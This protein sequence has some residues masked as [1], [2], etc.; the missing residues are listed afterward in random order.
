[1]RIFR[2]GP[3]DKAN[4]I[5]RCQFDFDHG[6]VRHALDRMA[7]LKVHLPNDASVLYAEGLI[8]TEGAGEGFAAFE[9]YKQAYTVDRDHPYAAPNAVLLAPSEA[10]FLETAEAA[11]RVAPHDQALRQI[12]DGVKEALADGRSPARIQMDLALSRME[13]GEFGEAA[14]H[15][16]IGLTDATLTPNEERDARRLRA[17]CL[18]KVDLMAERERESLGEAIPPNDRVALKAAKRELDKVI[19]I[20]EYD[21]EVWNLKAAWSSLLHDY[22]E[23]IESAEKALELRPHGYA[24]A[25]HNKA[26]ALFHLGRIDEAIASVEE[27]LRK[28]EASGDD[29]D[30][31]LSRRMLASYAE[32]ADGVSDEKLRECILRVAQGIMLTTEAETAGGHL[33]MNMDQLAAQMADVEAHLSARAVKY[34]PFL[35][36]MLT[37]VTPDTV[38]HATVTLGA[39]RRSPVEQYLLAA[40]YMAAHFDGVQRRDAARYVALYL[41]CQLEPPDVRAAYEAFVL[42]VD[43]AGGPEWADADEAVG[44]ELRSMQPFFMELITSGP[45]PDSMVEQARALLVRNFDEDIEPESGG[46]VGQA[47]HPSVR[48]SD[49]GPS[50]FLG[51]EPPSEPSVAPV[52]YTM[53]L[54]RLVAASLLSAVVWAALAAI[55]GLIAAYG[56][57]LAVRPID[58]SA[59]GLDQSFWLRL[60]GIGAAAGL[61]A[62]LLSGG[63]AARRDDLNGP[64]PVGGVPMGQTAVMVG[65]IPIGAI[66][67]TSIAVWSVGSLAPTGTALIA[68]LGRGFLGAFGGAVVAVQ[69]SKILFWTGRR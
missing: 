47:E 60:S 63:L 9:C 36:E 64:H 18:R 43:A 35:C 52:A 25:H 23:A 59:S 13:D 46:D 44:D 37:S 58:L 1:M 41:L 38:F 50:P 17:D 10:E 65:I 19:E 67:G 49:L 22:D 66:L 68:G 4:I 69:S 2:P 42:A 20:D 16:E 21:A 31:E 11:L 45:P 61:I 34:V 51:Y 14:A 53:T 12:I 26:N 3:D 33:D 5:R 57:H 15:A 48:G 39:Q 24:K 27:G 56:P 30:V 6:R 32:R 55:L 7:E 54:G 62:C 40:Q 29:G 28:A 8:R